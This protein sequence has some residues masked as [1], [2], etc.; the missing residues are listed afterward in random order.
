MKR[1]KSLVI[2]GAFL[3]MLLGV[4]VFCH[5]AEG[6]RAA[7]TKKKIKQIYIRKFLE[8]YLILLQKQKCR[9]RKMEITRRKQTLQKA[10]DRIRL[11]L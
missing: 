6:K 9:K 10:P 3:I 7:G 11:R 1:K 8:M 4:F 5:A 2:F